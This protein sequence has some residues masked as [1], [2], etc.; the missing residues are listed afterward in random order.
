[1]GQ[2]KSNP[3]AELAKR[4]KLPPKPKKPSKREQER[5]LR[6]AIF[7]E[8]VKRNPELPKVLSQLNTDR[9]VY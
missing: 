6:Q 5:M 7:S 3:V 4:G 8:I 1:M 2:H 9:G